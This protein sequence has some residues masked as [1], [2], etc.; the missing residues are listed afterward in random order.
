MFQNGE[1][2]ELVS[3]VAERHPEPSAE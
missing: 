3:E 1:L 2:Q